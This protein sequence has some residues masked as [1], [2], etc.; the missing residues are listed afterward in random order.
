MLQAGAGMD[1]RVDSSSAAQMPQPQDSEAEA[2]SGFRHPSSPAV[3]CPSQLK[4]GCLAQG[5]QALP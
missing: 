1:T 4:A 5:P 2:A 3:R